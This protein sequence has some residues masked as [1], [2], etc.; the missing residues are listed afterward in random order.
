[1]GQYSQRVLFCSKTNILNRECAKIGKIL[2]KTCPPGGQ[3][4]KIMINEGKFASLG[5]KFHMWVVWMD[6]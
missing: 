3:I 6:I 4:Q 2:A 5:L 1:M